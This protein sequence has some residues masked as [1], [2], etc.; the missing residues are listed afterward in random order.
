MI[1][2][3]KKEEKRREENTKQNEGELEKIIIITLN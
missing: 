3:L 2:D 1:V